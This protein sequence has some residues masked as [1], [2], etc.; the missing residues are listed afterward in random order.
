M[1]GFLQLTEQANPLAQTFRVTEPGG[2][3]ITGVGLFFSSAPAA[4]DLQIPIAVELR[5]VSDGGNPS[6][7][8]FHPGSRVTATAATVRAA[9]NT[10]YASAT[11]VKFT[12]K[13]P[14]YIASNVEAAIVISTTA[15]AGQ[16]K[17][18]LGR[19]A[20]F[21]DG[22]TTVKITS[23]LNSGSVF[24]SSNGT[25][26][27][28]DQFSDLAYKV[29][30][31]KFADA[32]ST[33][34]LIADAPPPKRLTESTRTKNIIKFPSSPLRFTAGSPLVRVIHPNHGFQNGDKVKLETD[35]DGFDS[36][37][38]INGISGANL[39]GTKSIDSADPFGYTFNCG[40]NADSSI[41][42]GGN[43]LMASQQYIIN[44]MKL[45]LAKKVP[46]YT[47]IYASANLT[48]SKSFAGS[49]TAYQTN[50]NIALPLKPGIQGTVTLSDPHVI[51]SIEQENEPTKLNGNPST[52][53]KI[54]L[55][56]QSAY[57]APY[58]DVES[59]ALVTRSNLIDYQDSAGA[60][61]LS[62]NKIRT[63]DFTPETNANGG[64][65]ASKHLTMVYQLKDTATSLRVFVDAIKP[66][67][68]DF[69]VWYRTGRA[70][71]GTPL[72]QK[73]W[74]KFSRSPNVRSTY[75]NYDLIGTTYSYRE[76]EF[77]VYD[78]TD[79]DEY[80]IKITMYSRRS[81]MVP[82]FKNLRT[83]ATV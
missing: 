33:A 3:Y 81:S 60:G 22:S 68:A 47:S 80:Q 57:G 24:M 1:A 36:A 32:A 50:S 79:F 64:T 40:S 20:E 28:A 78:V 12:F 44:D 9:A 25:A 29:Y 10:T 16:Y 6:S 59:A 61:L 67:T 38:T 21:L 55:N 26:W 65:N 77:N 5:P 13:H 69:D 70:Q 18:W 35:S 54:G 19:Q 34:Y 71:Q 46:P 62:R 72:K 14:V 7:K 23:D 39:L 74:T 76:F 41:R 45:Q 52:V 63:I 2:S 66:D 51:T 37:S 49:E 8:R 83:I 27:T 43:N 56:T 11:E 31:A 17:I 73:T 48:T 53:I 58:F 75:S 42:A 82:L 15:P 4:S 30:R